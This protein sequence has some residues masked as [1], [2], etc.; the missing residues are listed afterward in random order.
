MSVRPTSPD[1]PTTSVPTPEM[2]LKLYLT[3]DLQSSHDCYENAYI[4]GN[5]DS[6]QCKKEMRT[7]KSL[8]PT[9]G[10]KRAG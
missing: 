6:Q 7:W 4:G 3:F 10:Y 2:V 5:I 8:M 9:Y 1:R